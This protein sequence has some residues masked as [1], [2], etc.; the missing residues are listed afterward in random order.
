A[1]VASVPRWPREVGELVGRAPQYAF[2]AG[3]GALFI[4][5]ALAIFAGLVSQ[6]GAA[7]LLWGLLAL[8]VLLCKVVGLVGVA[9]G[10]G[11]VLRPLLP[12]TWRG[13]LPRTGLAMAILVVLS[14]LPWFGPA[15]W[16]VA[17]VV[18]VGGALS[19]VVRQLA[20]GR[21]KHG[22]AVLRE[23]A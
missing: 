13:E 19:W 1:L 7:L 9:W 12:L 17:N 21:A 15:L 22:P 18:G 20:L 14:W 16:V 23:V 4:W 11:C 5:L 6:G 2:L 10:V 8:P 3:L